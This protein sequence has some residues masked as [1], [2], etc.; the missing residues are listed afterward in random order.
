[1]GWTGK[2]HPRARMRRRPQLELLDDRC[3]LSTGGAIKLIEHGA[4]PAFDRRHALVRHP[5]EGSHRIEKLARRAGHHA[6]AALAAPECAIVERPAGSI[7]VGATTA[8]DPI[9]GAAAARSSFAVDGSGMTVAVIDTGVDYNN[10]ALGGAFGPNAKVIA[11]Y[12]FGDGTSDPLAT[13]S[14]HGTAI[15]G[16]I[17]SSDPSDLG[18]APGVKIV[19]LKVTDSSNTASLDNVANALQWVITNHS[20]YN[21]TPS[22]CRSRTAVITLR[23]GL[24]PTVERASKSRS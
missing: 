14:Q 20:A 2:K 16:L 9:T 3:L 23:T 13:T 8:Y 19:A 22:I 10:S 18:V 1:M 4:L 6:A 5:H 24:P 7:V 11:G 12:D 17:G 15:A 21:I